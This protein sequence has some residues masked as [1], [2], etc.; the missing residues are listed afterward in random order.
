M[1]AWYFENWL[2]RRELIDVAEKT[3]VFA[4]FANDRVDRTCKTGVF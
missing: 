3:R 2:K 4:F 1:L